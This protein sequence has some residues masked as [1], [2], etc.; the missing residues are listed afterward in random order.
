MDVGS[1]RTSDASAETGR[2]HKASA[3]AAPHARLARSP[4]VALR[5]DRGLLAEID[6]WAA[7]NYAATRSEAMRRL[8]ILGLR[9]Q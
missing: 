3:R 2:S 6:L 1:T 4:Y 9:S 5:I 8:I 7:I